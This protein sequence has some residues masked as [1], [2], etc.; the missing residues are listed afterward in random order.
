M[1]LDLTSIKSHCFEVHRI[2][3]II[4][5]SLQLIVYLLVSI[6]MQEK[7]SKAK[8]GLLKAMSP[9]MINMFQWKLKL[10]FV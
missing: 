1:T 7:D 10:I 2:A 8:L 4:T 5:S 3:F 9:L 6:A